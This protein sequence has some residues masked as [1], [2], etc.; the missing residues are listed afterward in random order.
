MALL[1][2]QPATGAGTTPSFT[3]AAAGGDTFQPGDD[4][5]LILKTSG[6]ASTVTV[7]SP[8]ACNQGSTHP[9]VISMP[10]TGERHVGPFPAQRFAGSNGLVSVTY[11]SVTGLTVAVVKA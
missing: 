7:A 4:V 6:T 2:Q 3:A 10:A 5:I 9:L 1:A 11:S 8:G